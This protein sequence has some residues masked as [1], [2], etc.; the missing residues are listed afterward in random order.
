MAIQ[1]QNMS[2]ILFLSEKEEQQNGLM[3][4]I[5]LKLNWSVFFKRKLTM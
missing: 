3:S 5:K 2:K 1:G 4:D